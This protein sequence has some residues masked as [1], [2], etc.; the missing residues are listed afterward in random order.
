MSF[1]KRLLS[2][3]AI[4][5]LSGIGGGVFSAVVIVAFSDDL[6]DLAIWVRTLRPPDYVLSVYDPR[7]LDANSPLP[8]VKYNMF[9]VRENDNFEGIFGERRADRTTEYDNSFRFKG[10]AR[11]G[12]MY[13]SYSPSH[14]E[15]FGS[16]QFQSFNRQERDVYFGWLI[17][18]YC[19]D[20]G[21]ST[22]RVLIGVLSRP[23]G[24]ADANRAALLMNGPSV[25]SAYNVDLSPIYNLDFSQRDCIFKPSTKAAAQ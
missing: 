19:N 15:R 3:A 22:Q 9:G 7:T 11:D 23:D 13:F 18:H 20:A 5:L 8:D 2:D 6:R 4:G 17:G 16:G 14:S 24:L 21:N 12:F 1:F 25:K 10:F